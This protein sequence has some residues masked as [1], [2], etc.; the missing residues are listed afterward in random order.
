MTIFTPPQLNNL[1]DLI[2]FPSNTL[3]YEGE[4]DFLPFKQLNDLFFKKKR[5]TEFINSLNLEFLDLNKWDVTSNDI[6]WL[7]I[8][9]KE[10]GTR[11]RI[12]SL[13]GH[14]IE[15]KN[16][17]ENRKIEYRYYISKKEYLRLRNIINI[18]IES[19]E[20]EKLYNKLITKYNL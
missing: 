8:K 16:I 6:D 14:Q 5:V 10:T 19:K 18:K 4:Y 2:N 12:H 7:V 1:P 20:M 17:S 15:Y 9:N 3:V 11:I 13:D